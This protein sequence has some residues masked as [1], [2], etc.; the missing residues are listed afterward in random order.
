MRSTCVA[1]IDCQNS[2]RLTGC[3]KWNIGMH[4]AYLKRHCW[5]VLFSVSLPT[6]S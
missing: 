2:V 1:A 5:K 4:D 3:K 6:S